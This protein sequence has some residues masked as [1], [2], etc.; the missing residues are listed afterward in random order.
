MLRLALAIWR[1]LKSLLE[2]D[3]AFRFRL[4]PY[5][6]FSL[7]GA[8][9]GIVDN[10]QENFRLSLE[11]WRRIPAVLYEGRSTNLLTQVVP[12]AWFPP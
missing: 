5:R 4:K 2:V 1:F 7:A 3:T 6:R 12:G 10:K 8:G 9:C 11:L